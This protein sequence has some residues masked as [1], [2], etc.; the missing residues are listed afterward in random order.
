M[1]F[2]F[3]ISSCG[4]YAEKFEFLLGFTVSLRNMFLLRADCFRVAISF[5]VDIFLKTRRPTFDRCLVSES[6]ARIWLPSPAAVG[7]WPRLYL[8]DI[9]SVLR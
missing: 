5:I 9:S 1:C 4:V 7:F 6:E 2:F 8:V 3:C